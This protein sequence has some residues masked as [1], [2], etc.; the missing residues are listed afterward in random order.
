MPIR[1]SRHGS[2][3]IYAPAS[4]PRPPLVLHEHSRVSWENSK[5]SACLES[6]Q[7]FQRIEI[8]AGGT[9]SASR[10]DL[11]IED[12]LNRKPKQRS[13]AAILGK[14]AALRSL[15]CWSEVK[16]GTFLLCCGRAARNAEF[17]SGAVYGS[18]Q[19]LASSSGGC[20]GGRSQ[21]YSPW[22]V[23]VMDFII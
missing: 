23:L 4:N 17:K 9:C 21:E 11:P 1:I 7:P 6:R 10:S 5:K 8:G 15:S 18:A 3:G 16:G 14:L 12:Q 20:Y 22:V 19:N 13:N 2:A